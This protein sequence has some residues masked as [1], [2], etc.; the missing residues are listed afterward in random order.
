MNNILIGD[1]TILTKKFTSCFQNST[2]S[3]GSEL[4]LLDTSM[5]ETASN[6]DRNSSQATTENPK[7]ETRSYEREITPKFNHGHKTK[8]GE[9]K[10]SFHPLY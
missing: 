8:N 6:S 1:P 5:M 3:Y 10:K 2:K 9:L 4:Y 7:S